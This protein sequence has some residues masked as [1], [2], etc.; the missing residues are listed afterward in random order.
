MA[1]PC[2]GTPSSWSPSQST[3][4]VIPLPQL[5]TTRRRPLSTSCSRCSES[6]A[7][8][9]ERRA[10]GGRKVVYAYEFAP[11]PAWVE[12]KEV[13]GRERACGMWPEERPAR[14][15]GSCPVNLCS[16]RC[17]WYCRLTARRG[18]APPRCSRKGRVPRWRRR[19]RSF[20]IR[21]GRAPVRGM[22]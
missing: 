10:E 14:G 22:R 16:G 20:V 4:A 7:V 18:R 3:P 6:V 9:V 11:K 2:T 19:L 21:V 15:S 17:Q 5:A 8:S 12:R 1:A 13:K